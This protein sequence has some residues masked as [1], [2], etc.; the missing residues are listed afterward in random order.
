MIRICAGLSSTLYV[1]ACVCM[2]G[3]SPSH[4]WL[5]RSKSRKHSFVQRSTAI[6]DH[7]RFMYPQGIVHVIR[8]SD[9]TQAQQWHNPITERACGLIDTAPRR[10]T[11]PPTFSPRYCSL[12]IWYARQL[13]MSQ[14]RLRLRALRCT[15]RLSRR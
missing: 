4:L 13:R 2:H 14:F 3:A 1:C 11:P 10:T 12:S 6:F 9:A 8:E 5:W 7:G 15:F